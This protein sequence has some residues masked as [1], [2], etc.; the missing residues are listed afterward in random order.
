MVG[1]TV[2]ESMKYQIICHAENQDC[3]TFLPNFTS[4]CSF[5]KT[6]QSFCIYYPFSQ[7]ATLFACLFYKQQS[8]VTLFTKIEKTT[9]FE[10]AKWW[11]EGHM[12]VQ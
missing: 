5:K 12:Q 4:L 2:W 1:K 6:L 10:E 9:V 8:V 3:W 11:A 7:N